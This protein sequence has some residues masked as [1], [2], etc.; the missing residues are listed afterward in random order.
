MRAVG[1][2]DAALFLV[3]HRVADGQGLHRLGHFARI[4]HLVD[5]HFGKRFHDAR[6]RFGFFGVGVPLAVRLGVG[7]AQHFANLDGAD[8]LFQFADFI[9]GNGEHHARFDLFYAGAVGVPDA[10]VLIVTHR[11]ADSDVLDF[12]GD[13][14]VVAE[15]AYLQIGKHR[16][17]AGRLIEAEARLVLG[18][19]AVVVEVLGPELRLVPHVLEQDKSRHFADV[20]VV[21]LARYFVERVEGERRNRV[22]RADVSGVA[23][24]DIGG[25]PERRRPLRAGKFAARVEQRRAAFVKER[26]LDRGQVQQFV[27]HDPVGHIVGRNLPVQK[28]AEF[29]VHESLL[30]SDGRLGQVAGFFVLLF[31]PLIP[32]RFVGRV[33][34]RNRVGFVVIAH[35]LADVNVLELVRD[36]VAVGLVNEFAE[37]DV[38]GRAVDARDLLIPVVPDGVARFVLFGS[39]F[40]QIADVQ[41]FENASHL[42]VAAGQF[43]NLRVGKRLGHLVEVAH[44]VVIPDGIPVLVGR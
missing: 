9:V 18:D 8:F 12:F 10:L 42:E 14:V 40:Q 23:R 19:F 13:L 33:G 31:I 22:G 35:R 7:I 39:I 5:G 6:N 1:V 4:L 26:D 41:P 3:A 15:F 44:D 27:E 11:V 25:I 16:E 38:G 17:N 20:H 34:V 24:R 30:D 2:P 21:H 37:V 32:Y 28:V 43:G 29:V 36:R